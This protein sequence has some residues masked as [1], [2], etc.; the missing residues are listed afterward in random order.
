MSDRETRRF[1]SGVVEGEQVC[2]PV[3]VG[4]ASVTAHLSSRLLWTAVDHGAED[5]ALPA[6]GGL[7]N[8]LISQ[9]S[10]PS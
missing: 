1:I 5:G 8:R 4:V 9:I 7:V 10:S 6:V 2:L 3:G